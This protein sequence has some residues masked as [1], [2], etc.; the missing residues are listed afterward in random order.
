MET[1]YKI[2]YVD[3]PEEYTWG[4]VGRSLDQF[5]VEQAGPLDHT[6]LCYAVFDANQEV[7]GGIIGAVYW[8]WLYIDLL[9]LR[10]ELRGKGYGHELLTQMEDQARR[11]G[12]KNVYLDTFSFQAP[13]FYRRHGYHVF[14]ELPDFPAGHT[15]YFMTKAL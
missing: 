4:F 3:K 15:R 5:N 2:A 13:E 6:R 7:L 8:N 10:D 1:E 14:G 9:W 11:L 12:A